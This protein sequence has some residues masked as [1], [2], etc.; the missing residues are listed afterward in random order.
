MKRIHVL[1]SFE[2]KQLMKG[3]VVSMGEGD[4][5]ALSPD[6]LDGAP[7]RA[8]RKLHGKRKSRSGNSQAQRSLEFYQ[9]NFK[10]G[11]KQKSACRHC[12]DVFTGKHH[13]IAAATHTRRSHPEVWRKK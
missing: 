9:Q 5:L 2:L 6:L 12:Q 4:G 8:P 1:E 7:H 3:R 11:P 10:Q 13:R